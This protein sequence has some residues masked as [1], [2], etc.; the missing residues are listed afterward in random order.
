[1]RK[2]VLVVGDLPDEAADR[3]GSKFTVIRLPGTPSDAVL[4]RKIRNC[5]G[6]LV[7]IGN[8]IDGRVF[9][10]APR[11]ECVANFGVGYDHID[12]E[13]ARRAGVVVTNTPDVLTDATA[14][15]AWALILACARRLPEGERMVRR[16]RFKGWHPRMLLGVDLKG[17]TLGIYGFGRIGQAVARRGAGWGMKVIYHQRHRV[18]RALERELNARMTGFDE[19]L[20]NSDIISVNA[21][22]T[23]QTRGR[24]GR[25]EFSRMKPNAIFVNTAR[26]PLHDEAELA[27]ALRKGRL[28][29]AGLDVYEREPRVHPDLIGLPNCVLLPHLGSGTVGTRRR[30]ALLA[31]E[32]LE[33]VL[34]GRTPSTPVAG[35]PNRPCR[36]T[37]S[38]S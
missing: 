2:K 14:D 20:R 21:P 30:M 7:L 3:L 26:G 4:R 28:F 19:L 5:H 16:G 36:K 22:L 25:R 15:I 27:R 29:S 37:G 34:L 38:G 12:V 1:M 13:A 6:A 17:A 8:R 9:R 23:P 24:F 10:E 11:L 18:S 32:N 33:R 35:S 31:A